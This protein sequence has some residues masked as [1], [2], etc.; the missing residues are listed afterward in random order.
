MLSIPINDVLYGLLTTPKLAK[1]NH[2]DY[3]YYAAD[4][5]YIHFISIE[6]PKKSKKIKVPSGE[7]VDVEYINS[8]SIFIVYN[9]HENFN[10][11]YHLIIVNMQ[12]SVKKRINLN[13]YNFSSKTYIVTANCTNNISMERY[14]IFRIKSDENE[15]NPFKQNKYPQIGCYDLLCDT[16]IYNSDL[17]FPDFP[18]NIRISD[19]PEV[20]YISTFKNHFPLIRYAYSPYV[21]VWDLKNN[22]TIKH[23]VHSKIIDS[24]YNSN[25]YINAVFTEVKINPYKGHKFFLCLPLLSETET[26]KPFVIV[27]DSQYHYMTESVEPTN[28][29]NTFFSENENIKID[30]KGDK[31]ILTYFN[32]YFENIEKSQYASYITS[33]K[34]E[35]K[36]KQNEIPN[37]VCNIVNSNKLDTVYDIMLLL[38]NHF[39]LKDS[40]LFILAMY[41]E[42]GCSSCNESLIEFLSSH[43][44]YFKNNKLYVLLSS[45][46]QFANFILKKYKFNNYPYLLLDT[47]NL[48][49]YFNTSKEFIPRLV[50]IKNFKK[51]Y[52]YFY[53]LDAEDSLETK[54]LKISNHNYEK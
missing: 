9:P 54:L 50:E 14:F 40:N 5:S 16:V 36:A 51:Q 23:L 10:D 18:K 39:Q 45:S 32:Y 26:Y 34:K 19:R 24:I 42:M 2:E 21:Y 29:L 6:N 47:L 43:Y 38:R 3:L 27:T 41:G 13:K 1:I 22:K 31:I 17:F 37:L 15:I 20:I 28:F 4:F 30:V 33:L 25:N 46:K 7:I 53:K 48:Y 12:G 11:K 8:D 49:S 35:I 44:I 52:D